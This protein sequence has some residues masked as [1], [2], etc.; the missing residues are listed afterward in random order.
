M[1][2]PFY[3]SIESSGLSH[4]VLIETTSPFVFEYIEAPGVMFHF[5]GQNPTVKLHFF[6]GPSP[7]EVYQQLHAYVRP[8]ILEASL[9]ISKF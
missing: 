4:G 1:E 5:Q 7:A 3:T 8:F 6:P 2:L 9:L